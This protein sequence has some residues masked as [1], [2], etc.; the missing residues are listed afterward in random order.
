MQ[1][2]AARGRWGWNSDLVPCWLRDLGKR[3]NSVPMVISAWKGAVRTDHRGVTCTKCW[4]RHLMACG[5]VSLSRSLQATG[6]LFWLGEL[7]FLLYLISFIAM[8]GPA[9]FH[10]SR[11][12]FSVNRASAVNAT[13]P[14][15]CL[16]LLLPSTFS[17]P[18]IYPSGHSFSPRLLL[19][20]SS[21]AFNAWF[22]F[23]IEIP[24]SKLES[25]HVSVSHQLVV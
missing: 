5:Q 1:V 19:V 17:Y 15:H 21:I 2:W 11:D 20:I 4:A 8:K 22:I 14:L 9:M 12:T 23:L 18:H 6:K 3:P 25:L 10:I 24:S 16:L 7:V 13:S